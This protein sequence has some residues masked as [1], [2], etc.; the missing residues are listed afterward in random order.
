MFILDKIHDAISE[1]R[2]EL[3]PYAPRLVRVTIPV[4]KIGMVIGPG[5]KTI[6]GIV[7]TTGATVDVENDGTVTIGAA[8]GDAS[9]LAVK[10]VKDLVRE[11]QRGE[12][13]TGKV[14]KIMN[15]GAFV[16]LTPGKDGMVHISELADYHVK[17]V[18]DI[19]QLGEEITVLVLDVDPTGRIKLS[20]RALLKDTNNEEDGDGSNSNPL[21][22]PPRTGSESGVR[23]I[24]ASPHRPGGGRPGGNRGGYRQD[25]QRGG[26]SRG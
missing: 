22:S 4:D 7:E 11:I 8:D 1:V 15:F 16:E 10:M 23:Q 12:I 24:E 2:T 14:V 18:E 26:A 6:R 20:R 25:G 9:D 19:V 5:G 21:S 17:A 13:F 3:S